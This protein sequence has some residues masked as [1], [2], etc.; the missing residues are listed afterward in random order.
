MSLADRL[1]NWRRAHTWFASHGQC[2][3]L[4]G[5][6]R[7]PQHW[8]ELT[9]TIP[10]LIDVLDAWEVELAWR[11]TTSKARWVIK[12]SVMDRQ[13]VSWPERSKCARLVRTMTASNVQPR[14]WRQHVQEAKQEIADALTEIE[15]GGKD[16]VLQR[17][18]ANLLHILRMFGIKP[19][20]ETTPAFYAVGAA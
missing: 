13:D 6:W 16:T 1:D 8:E 11:S 4:E 5:R 18:D 9:S 12:L 7:S 10:P 2:F 20:V 3:S 14:E 17:G 19:S 15:F